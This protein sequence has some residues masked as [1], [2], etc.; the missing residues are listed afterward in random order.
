MNRGLVL[1]RSASTASKSAA[2]AYN[3]KI[4]EYLKEKLPEIP[5]SNVFP[6]NLFLK[7]KQL[8]P[9]EGVTAW[10]KLPDAEKKVRHLL[11]AS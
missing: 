8:P 6:I 5:K 7:Q 9:K 11:Y 4:L 2:A 10:G 3:R 1:I